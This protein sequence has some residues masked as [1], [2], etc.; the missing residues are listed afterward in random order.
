MSKFWSICKI[1][2]AQTIRQRNQLYG[3]IRA[4]T[5]QGTFQAA[6]VCSI[7][8]LFGIA[9]NIITPDLMEVVY[10]TIYGWGLIAVIVILQILGV[11][12]I[13]KIVNIDV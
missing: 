2:F 10:T 7:P 1:T 8:V 9:I 6:L 11:F 13:L 4:L 5:A 12:T 3:K